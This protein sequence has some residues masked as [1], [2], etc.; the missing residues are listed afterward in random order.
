MRDRGTASRIEA[1]TAQIQLNLER[2]EEESK[3]RLEVQCEKLRKELE[4]MRKKVDQ[5]QKQFRDIVKAW[6]RTN[7]E[8]RKK[9]EGAE[10]RE[11]AAREQ[12]VANWKNEGEID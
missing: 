7:T 10:G 9:A 2:R 5:E 6:E 1:S 4:L 11:K 8:L 12:M 3:L